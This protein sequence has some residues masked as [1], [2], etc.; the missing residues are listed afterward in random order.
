[1]QGTIKRLKQDKGFGFIL[2]EDKNEY[3]FHQSAL[4]N[5]KFEELEGRDVTFEESE[6]SKGLR[7]EDIYV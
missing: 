7:A 4:K 1:M 6:G 3:F 2:G 5:V